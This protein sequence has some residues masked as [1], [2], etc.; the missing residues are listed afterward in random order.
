MRLGRI[1]AFSF[2]ALF[3][4]V[5]IKRISGFNVKSSIQL[6]SQSVIARGKNSPSRGFNLLLFAGK[7]PPEEGALGRF[8]SPRLDD[9][10]LVLADALLAQVVA[11]TFQLFTISSIK[12]PLP[13]WALPLFPGLF[14]TRG[15]LVAPTLIHGAGLAFCWIA[16]A[17]AAKAYE[18][19]AFSKDYGKVLSRTLQAGAFATGI[20]IF[21]TQIDLLVEFKGQYIEWGQSEQTDLRLLQGT[22]E[23]A[24]DVIFEA[25]TLTTWRLYRASITTE[26]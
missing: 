23:V 20:L 2:A 10:G 19:E 3:I 9:P 6:Q 7:T 24:N 15:S 12:A 4:A 5:Q 17:L 14:D 11:P 8:I 26:Q 16:G 22:V 21:S 13:S 25:L 1:R 18:Q